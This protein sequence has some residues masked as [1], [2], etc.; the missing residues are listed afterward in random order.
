MF[1]YGCMETKIK[2]SL[3]QIVIIPIFTPHK[4]KFNSFIEIFK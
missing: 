1:N 2:K 4:Q 3:Y